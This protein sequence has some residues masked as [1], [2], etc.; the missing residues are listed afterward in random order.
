ML[1]NSS[2]PLEEN[3]AATK[4]A[5]NLCAAAGV[6]MEGEL[7]HI[8]TAKDGVSAEHTKTDEAV[9]FAEETG[10]A[11]LAVLVGTAHGRYQQ[12]PVL[13]I[14]RIREIAEGTGLPLVLHG[15]S[16]VPDEQIQAAVEAGIKK[17][18]ISKKL[19]HTGAVLRTVCSF[20]E[21]GA[22]LIVLSND[23]RETESGL[24]YGLHFEVVVYEEGCNVWRIVPADTPRK[25]APTALTRQTFPLPAGKPIQLEVRVQTGMLKVRVNDIAFEAFSDEIPEQ[26]YAGI[27]GCEGINQF[28]EFSAGQEE[29]PAF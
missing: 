9:R 10:I 26:F 23:I 29:Q 2:L 16:G 27:T 13:N 21:Y 12:A 8:G 20:S 14:R 1:D 3:I 7:G 11:A 15:G 4:E 24:C 18:M 17:I 25:I 22:P 19:Y 28:Y 5:V 6:P